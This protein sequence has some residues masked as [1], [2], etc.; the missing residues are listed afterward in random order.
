M[1]EL[2]HTDNVK[3]SFQPQLHTLLPFSPISRAI[4]ENS[5]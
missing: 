1:N 4:N 2:Y 3:A 5:S